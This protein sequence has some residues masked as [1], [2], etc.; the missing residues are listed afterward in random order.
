MNVSIFAETEFCMY[1]MSDQAQKDKRTEFSVC[2]LSLQ[3]IACEF[4]IE[5]SFVSSSL[6]LSTSHSISQRCLEVM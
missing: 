5:F 3:K 2:V 1:S 4:L 6:N